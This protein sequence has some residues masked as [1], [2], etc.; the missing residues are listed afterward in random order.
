MPSPN[1][2]LAPYTKALHSSSLNV[3]CVWVCAIVLR[4]CHIQTIVWTS[5]CWMMVT[6]RLLHIKYYRVFSNEN[7]QKR[8]TR[9]SQSHIS[10]LIAHA[11][12]SGFHFSSFH[13]GIFFLSIVSSRLD[14]INWILLNPVWSAIK[15]IIAQDEFKIVAIK[16]N[17]PNYSGGVLC[18]W[19][20]AKNHQI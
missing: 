2:Q 9:S 5:I 7:A 12:C 17:T 14:H 3:W 18:E 20:C 4:I 8:S 1:R 15:W 13:H 10:C 6:S 11:H 19:S 16:E